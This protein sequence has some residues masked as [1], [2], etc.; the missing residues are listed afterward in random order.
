MKRSAP[1]PQ[2][3]LRR[4]LM[5]IGL[6]ALGFAA[7]A[8]LILSWDRLFP[9]PPEQQVEVVWT[10]ECH[11]ARGWIAALREQGF[12]VRDFEM[13]DLAAVRR[14]WHTPDAADGCHPGHFLGYVLDGHVPGEMLR[15][16]AQ[17]RP[18]AV[19]LLQAHTDDPQDIRFELLAADGSRRA[20]P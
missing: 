14:R 11:C 6:V 4:P 5:R 16:L 17:E 1:P 10:H 3:S 13:Q 2:R 8:G 7:V 20:W 9:V 18:Q 12:V 19:A 15:R